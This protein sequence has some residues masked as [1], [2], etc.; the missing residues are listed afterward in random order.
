MS[1]KIT[2]KDG[3]ELV[4]T[5]NKN[6]NGENHEFIITL[7]KKDEHNFVVKIVDETEKIKLEQEEVERTRLAAVAAEAARVAAEQ[8]AAEAA[9]IAAA[10]QEEQEKNRLLEE[11]RLAAEAAEA[12]RVAAEE[13]AEA[14]RVAAAVLLAEQNTA[15][16]VKYNDNNNKYPNIAAAVMA[17]FNK[18]GEVAAVLPA[19]VDA[20]VAKKQ[21]I[22]NLLNAAISMPTSNFKERSAK[23]TALDNIFIKAAILNNNVRPKTLA[24]V[25]TMVGLTG[26]SKK[27]RKTHKSQKRKKTK[28]LRRRK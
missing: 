16:E 26:G 15:A 10:E 1:I 6:V 3:N 7:V 14:A 11:S 9:R 23:Q 5:S 25:K 12:A 13:A 4:F 17:A 21:E 8:A 20:A 28:T 24:E 2:P 19:P 18:L 27:R 22:I